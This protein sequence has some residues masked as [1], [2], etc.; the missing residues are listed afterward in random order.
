MGY[1]LRKIIEIRKLATF[2]I[3]MHDKI[4]K[5]NFVIILYA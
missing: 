4:A 2:V 1:I 3:I 5:N